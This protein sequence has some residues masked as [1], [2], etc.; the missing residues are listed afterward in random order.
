MGRR[1]Y[2][3]VIGIRD[4][5]H[6]TALDGAVEDATNVRDWLLTV[7]EVPPEHLEFVLGDDS[8]RGEPVAGTIEKAF[9]A[10]L[11]S[12]RDEGARRL[13]VYFAGHGM[14]AAV[15]RLSLLLA[16]ARKGNWGRSIDSEAYHDGLGNLPVFCEQVFWYDCCRFFDQHVHG[17]GPTWSWGDPEPPI[18]FKQ[19][20]H[21]GA[22]FR[23]AANE[24]D[25]L[26][27][28]RG[29]FT[30]ALLGG[31]NG[32]AAT[33]DEGVGVVT[34]GGLARFVR[35]RVDELARER[36]LSQRPEPRHWGDPDEFVLVEGVEPAARRI[37]V[38]VGAEPGELRVSDARMKEV[39]RR[40]FAA[41]AGV[42]AVG[43]A[44]GNYLVEVVH[45][46][47][48]ARIVTVQASADELRV[49]LVECP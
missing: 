38:T 28:T 10:V 40:E 13:Y 8:R 15:T 26:G 4:Y 11:D 23:S 44:P 19:L 35:N 17:K 29:L 3:V 36:G 33:F 5:L 27:T 37:A 16:D 25:V 18:D 34:A 48:C 41:G 1:D 9:D 47:E 22:A 43:L 45:K 42:V 7:G 31:L 30:A 39:L 24:L 46:P 32:E 20:V 6:L 12:A 49:D 2:A 14:S 21:Y